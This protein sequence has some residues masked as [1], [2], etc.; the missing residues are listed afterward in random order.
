[1]EEATG[2]SIIGTPG[3]L[4]PEKL[5]DGV[6]TK[7]HLHAGDIWCLGE[8]A[9]RLLSNQP[10][11]STNDDLRDY[12]CGRIQFPSDRLRQVQAS[13]S[14]IDFIATAMASR[15]GG[16]L[17]AHQAAGHRWINAVIT[18]GSEAESTSELT[19]YCYITK[20]R[21]STDV[22]LVVLR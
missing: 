13:E 2:G 18:T 8:T 7:A 17:S 4:A 5:V 11:F 21:S 12:Y 15:P 16:R 10:V 6:S 22:F 14:A 3:F 1:M 19:R 20:I 9:F